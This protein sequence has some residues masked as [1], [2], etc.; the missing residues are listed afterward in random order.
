MYEYHARYIITLLILQGVS[1]AYIFTVDESV[2]K[3]KAKV[4]GEGR[5]F[6]LLL[7]SGLDH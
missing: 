6:V 2:T 7:V 1:H 3:V 4:I 5:R